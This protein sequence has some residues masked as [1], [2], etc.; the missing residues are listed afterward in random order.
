MLL[1]LLKAIKSMKRADRV[2]GDLPL[3]CAA[4]ASANTSKS[5]LPLKIHTERETSDTDVKFRESDI[6]AAAV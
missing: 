2:A 3:C 4:E 6:T 5:G 1:L